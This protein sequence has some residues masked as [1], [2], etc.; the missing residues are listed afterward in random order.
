MKINKKETIQNLVS[1]ILG[2]VVGYWITAIESII[3]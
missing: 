3:P 2:I 1:Y